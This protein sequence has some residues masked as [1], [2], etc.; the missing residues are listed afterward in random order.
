MIREWKSREHDLSKYGWFRDDDIRAWQL[1]VFDTNKDG[2][3]DRE[4]RTAAGSFSRRL[5]LEVELSSVHDLAGQ[6]EHK[7]VAIEIDFRVVERTIVI[8]NP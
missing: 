7:P 1:R 3:L 5:E 8:A 2:T 6:W 4:E